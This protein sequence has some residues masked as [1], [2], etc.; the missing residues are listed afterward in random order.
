MH[1]CNSNRKYLHRVFDKRFNTE[2][3][4]NEQTDK[5]EFEKSPLMLSLQIDQ[6]F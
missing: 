5:L 6:I 4:F 2:E 3:C 1:K